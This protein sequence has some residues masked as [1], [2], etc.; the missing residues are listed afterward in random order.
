MKL[1][2]TLVGTL[3]P[4]LGLGLGLGLWGLDY[5]SAF[6]IQKQIKYEHYEQYIF[7]LKFLSP[8]LVNTHKYER[9]PNKQNN[10]YCKSAKINSEYKI[11]SDGQGFNT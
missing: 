11:S 2:K 8:S 7:T 3:N 4:G 10:R 5:K 6:R 1:P 9:N